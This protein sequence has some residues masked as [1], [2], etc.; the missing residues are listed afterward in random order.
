MYLGQFNIGDNNI[1][2]EDNVRILGLHIDN[3]LNFNTQITNICQKA[4][5][6]VQVLSRLCH[7]LDQFNKMLLYNSFVGCY[8]I[9]VPLYDI[10][11]VIVIP[12]KL[13]RLKKSN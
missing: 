10:L 9:T 12:I 5:R 3:T 4:G 2:P 1:F 13:R 6:K 8:L 11:S 7:V